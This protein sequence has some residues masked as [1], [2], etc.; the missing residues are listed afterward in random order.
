MIKTNPKVCGIQDPPVESIHNPSWR[1]RVGTQLQQQKVRPFWWNSTL[2]AV[3]SRVDCCAKLR[4]TEITSTVAKIGSWSFQHDCQTVG[5]NQ[6][7]K[8]SMDVMWCQTWSHIF[9]IRS[10]LDWLYCPLFKMSW[11]KVSL[12]SRLLGK[13][14][15]QVD[16]STLPTSDTPISMQL[17]GVTLTWDRGDWSA[18]IEMFVRSIYEAHNWKTEKVPVGLAAYR[19]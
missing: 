13:T 9:S 11:K 4:R 5:Q 14:E 6:F 2:G 3:S 15:Q 8:P 16:A 10:C 19:P 12:F 7:F 18:G 1:I 17:D